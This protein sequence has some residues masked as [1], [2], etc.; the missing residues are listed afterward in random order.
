MLSDST[1]LLRC[2]ELIEQKLD[3]GASEVWTSVD[4]ENLQQ[5]ILDETGVSLSA[6]TLRRIWGRVDYQHLPSGTTLN[7]LAQF[8]GYSDWRV[9]IRSQPTPALPLNPIEPAP[10]QPIN[11]RINWRRL[12]WISGAVVVFALLG[13][14]AFE[15]KNRSVN[16]EQYQFSSKPLTRTIPNSVIF[17]YDASASPTDSV[18]IQQSWDTHL[19]ASVSK[20]GPTY[21]SIYYEPGFYQA[22]LIVG[23]RVVKEHPLLIP[24]N[25]WL[26]TISNKPVPIYIKPTVFMEP[27][28][29]CLPI[30]TIQAQNVPLQPQ[31]PLVKYFNVGNFEPVPLTDFSFSSNVKN[32]YNEGSATC[33]F[34]WIILV[35]NGMP[36]TIPLSTKGCVSELALLD[37]ARTIS[38]KTADLSSFGVDLTNWV[39]VTCRSEGGKLYVSINDKVAFSSALPTKKMDIVGLIYGFRGTG[40]VKDIMLRTAKNKLIFQAF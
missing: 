28:Q 6:S 40:A 27:G 33:Q 36:I 5:R 10:V 19:R 11:Q 38:G 21:T 13:I 31:T 7:T 1:D 37:G 14:V 16:V 17:T 32:D 24:T 9:F 4:F 26:A 22:K 35:T 8:A 23:N 2:K 18:Y 30:I 25:G 3:W 15:Q 39:H 29:M 34:S 12:G 20:A